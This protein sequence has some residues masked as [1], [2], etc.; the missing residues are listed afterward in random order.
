[1]PLGGRGEGDN[2]VAAAADTA[3]NDDDNGDDDDDAAADAALATKRGPCRGRAPATAFVAL[4]GCGAH[5]AGAVWGGWVSGLEAAAA[6]EHHLLD[7]RVCGSTWLARAGGWA[8]RRL[9]CRE[10]GW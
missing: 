2:L 9:D 6:A 5:P 1:M 7:L 8:A 4:A 3:A 10:A